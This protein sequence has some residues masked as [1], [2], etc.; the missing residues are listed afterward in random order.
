M[1][2]SLP[3]HEEFTV[4]VL[5]R[6]EPFL[7]LVQNS[8]LV[9]REIRRDRCFRTKIEQLAQLL[10]AF[11]FCQRFKLRQRRSV[12]AY[13]V[14]CVESAHV[15]YRSV[16][17]RTA[18]SRRCRRVVLCVIVLLLRNQR[19][20]LVCRHDAASRCRLRRIMLL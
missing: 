2:I 6:V 11:Q 3:R 16:W 14:V 18:A 19:Q 9:G 4:G 13:N 20:V 12:V 1:I 10:R 15:L 17:Q 5:K 8:H 7:A